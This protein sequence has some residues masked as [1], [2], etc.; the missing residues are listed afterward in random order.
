[1]KKRSYIFLI[2][3]LLTILIAPPIF[4]PIIHDNDNPKSAIRNLIYKDGHP[5]QSFFA[6][7]KDKQ[8]NDP[9]YG[10]MYD[11]FWNDWN[12]ETGQTGNICYA[13]KEDNIFKVHYGTGP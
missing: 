3:I 12:S 5:Y 2:V 13:K 11:V 10:H 1:M 6:M 4:A 8:I 7:I 9:E